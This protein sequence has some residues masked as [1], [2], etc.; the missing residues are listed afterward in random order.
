MNIYI[1]FI[2]IASLHDARARLIMAQETSE[3]STY[4]EDN[5]TRNQRHRRPIYHSMDIKQYNKTKTSNKPSCDSY[6]L[7]NDIEDPPS[8]INLNSSDNKGD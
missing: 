1:I 3:L 8:F 6:F 7:G 5:S 2:I 4:E